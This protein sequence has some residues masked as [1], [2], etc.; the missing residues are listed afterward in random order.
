MNRNSVSGADLTIHQDTESQS[1]PTVDSRA[2]YRPIITVIDLKRTML[3]TGVYFD[4]IN[5]ST[6]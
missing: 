6:S 4:G 1:P 3:G 5:F 2:W